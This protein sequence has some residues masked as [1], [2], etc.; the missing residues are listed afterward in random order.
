MKT[1]KYQNRDS[2]L[3]TSGKIV[4]FYEREFYCFSNFSSFSVKWKGRVWQTSEHAYQAS[5]F[6]GKKPKVVEMIFKAK[7]ADTAYRIAQKNLGKKFEDYRDRDLKNME[8]IVKAKLKQNPYVMHKLLQTGKRKIVEDSPKD[9][10]WGWGADKKGR[11]ELGKI[12]MKLR[13]GV[14]GSNGPRP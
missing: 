11:N 1:T 5:R 12:W 13:N 10:F 6:M 4:G 8:S 14:V 2:Q 7:S 3:E 9:S